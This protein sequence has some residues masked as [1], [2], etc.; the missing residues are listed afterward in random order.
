V[1][2]NLAGQIVRSMLVV[3]TMTA[4]AAAQTAVKPGRWEFSSQL[5]LPSAAQLPPGVSL[6]PGVQAQ[7]GGGTSATHTSCIDPDKAVPTDPRQGC[8]IDSMKRSAGTI[9]WSTT[10]TSQQ[11][12]IR[13]EGVAHYHGNTMDGTMTTHVPTG[14]GQSMTNTMK[15]TGRYLGP[16]TR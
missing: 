7:P 4:A 16:C 3:V 8:K 10:C 15:I 9:T 12:T 1:K 11:G 13:S 2:P 14:A 5:Q 6:P